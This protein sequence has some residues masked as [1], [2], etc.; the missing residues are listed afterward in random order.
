MEDQRN[1]RKYDIALSFAGE[2]RVYVEEVARCLRDQGI[3]VFYDLYEEASLWGKNLYEHLCD[4]YQNQASYTVMFISKEYSAKLWTN[5]ERQSA[6]SR[7]FEE[8]QEYILP[9][10]FDDT[11]VPG[12]LRTIGYV[13]LRDRTPA[14]FCKLIVTKLGAKQRGVR[15][16][17]EQRVTRAKPVATVKRPVSASLHLSE[18]LAKVIRLDFDGAVFFVKFKFHYWAINGSLYDLWVDDRLEFSGKEN[19]VFHEENY[20]YRY[21]GFVLKAHRVTYICSVRWHISNPIPFVPGYL[22]FFEILVDRKSV[23]KDRR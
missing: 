3:R 5:H 11:E 7:A 17:P 23:F 22:D 21:I 8:R 4:V 20:R 15:A 16:K 1:P 14:E 10:R 12:L 2:N 6:Q 13:D 19:D 9:A 18:N